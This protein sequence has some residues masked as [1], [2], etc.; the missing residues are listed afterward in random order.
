MQTIDL[1]RDAILTRWRLILAVILVT[2]IGTTVAVYIRPPSFESRAAL[3]VNVERHRLSVAR[4]DVRTDGAALQAVEAVTSHAEGLRSRLLAEL[5][6]DKLDPKIFERKRS[7]NIILRSISDVANLLRET[8]EDIL[9]SVKLMPPKNPRYELIKKIEDGFDVST[10]RQAQV[11]R[12]SFRADNPKTAQLVLE[13]L[14]NTYIGLNAERIE[15]TDILSEKAA[16]LRP[17]LEEAERGLGAI[18][19]RYGIVDLNGEKTMLADRIGRLMNVLEDASDTKVSSITSS[20]RVGD[21]VAASSTGA[22]QRSVLDVQDEPAS[23]GVASAQV[24]QMRAQL[25]RLRLERAGLLDTYSPGR[26]NVGPLDT[27]I[28]NLRL[29]LDE[30]IAKIRDTVAGYRARLAILLEVEP[31]ITQLSRNVSILS[32]T[33]EVYRKEADDR[34]IMRSQDALEQLKIIDPPSIPYA[35]RGPLPVLLVLSGFGAGIVLGL[36]AALLA[37]FFERARPRRHALAH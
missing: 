9:R 5:V 28:D 20:V 26:A 7:N 12:L 32:D 36:G 4:A 24:V 21:R 1:L 17:Q 3:F 34:L 37:N 23:G 33:Y 2:T 11:I 10:V 25:N 30:E 29:Q 13:A 15:G 6:V 16:S 31:Q 8:G 35:P 18:K 14:L 19:A 27:R 22:P